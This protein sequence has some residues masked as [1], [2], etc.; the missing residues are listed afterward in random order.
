MIDVEVD[1]APVKSWLTSLYS[2]QVPFATARALTVIAEEGRDA[3]VTE[4]QG[5][6]ILRTTW[7]KQGG[8]FG[9][10]RKAATKKD[11]VAEIFTRAP[12]MKI[13]ETGGT[14]RPSGQ[15]LALPTTNVRRTKRDIISKANRPANLKNTT[16]VNRGGALTLTRNTTRTSTVMYILKNS[17]TI[18]ARLNF[19]KTAR[20]IFDKRW[21][22]V[23]DAELLKAI[24]TAK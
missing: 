21:K 15:H 19:Q 22:I 13:H 10:N 14:K 24:R 20:G 8:Q 3:V 1:F 7:W 23:F 11:L 4:L 17:A 18:R 2:S 5:A 9:F 12:W 6:F 16:K